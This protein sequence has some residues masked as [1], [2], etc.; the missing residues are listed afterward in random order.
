MLGVCERL[1][2]YANK[3]NP[4]QS[5]DTRDSIAK[6]ICSGWTSDLAHNAVPVRYSGW[7]YF[8]CDS[9]LTVEFSL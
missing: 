5:N 7:V 1:S 9:L 4:G 8:I 2:C 3:G 6:V